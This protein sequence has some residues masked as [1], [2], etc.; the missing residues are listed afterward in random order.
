MSLFTVV[1]INA[2]LGRDVQVSMKV[3]SK[4]YF[5]ECKSWQR[6]GTFKCKSWPRLVTSKKRQ[7]LPKKNLK[8]AEKRQNSQKT[9]EMDEKRQK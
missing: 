7:K 1:S 4:T 8:K 9:S 6:L 5:S 2:S 3:L